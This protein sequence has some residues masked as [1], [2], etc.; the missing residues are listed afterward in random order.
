[1]LRVPRS[2]QISRMMSQLGLADT[3]RGDK[4]AIDQ[5]PAPSHL[6]SAKRRAFAAFGGSKIA[7]WREHRLNGGR[8]QRTSA[9]IARHARH[10]R[11]VN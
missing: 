4:P 6:Q 3:A 1:L 5:R 2:R 9:M 11:L 10:A 7:R 8:V